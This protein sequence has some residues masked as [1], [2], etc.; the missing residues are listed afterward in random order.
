M[1]GFGIYEKHCM[2]HSQLEEYCLLG[3]DIM[4]NLFMFCLQFWAGKAVRQCG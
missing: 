2:K 3:Y 4:L 1:P